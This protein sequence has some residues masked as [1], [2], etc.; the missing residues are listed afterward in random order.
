MGFIG[1]LDSVYLILNCSIIHIWL[2]QCNV[3]V[4][5]AVLLMGSACRR[6]HTMTCSSM[7]LPQ[8]FNAWLLHW[9]NWLNCSIYLLTINIWT[10]SNIRLLWYNVVLVYCSQVFCSSEI[11]RALHLMNYK[12]LCQCDNFKAHSLFSFFLLLWMCPR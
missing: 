11:W 3:V 9:T 5:L 6:H 12:I 4:E 2:Q 10:S 8:F 1:F 7:S